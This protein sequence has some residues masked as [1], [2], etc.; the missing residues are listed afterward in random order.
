ME[1]MA[2]FKAKLKDFMDILMKR[3]PR[4]IFLKTVMGLFLYLCCD[5][6]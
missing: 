2:K 4:S 3:E 1:G 5:R 6:V